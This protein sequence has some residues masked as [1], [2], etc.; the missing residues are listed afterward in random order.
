MAAGTRNPGA[1]PL[2]LDKP[3]IFPDYRADPISETVVNPLIQSNRYFSA[4]FEDSEVSV[5]FGTDRT[6][7]HFL[8][9]EI[10]LTEGLAAS[11]AVDPGMAKAAIEAMRGFSPDLA[12]IEARS[13]VDGLA[14]P[15]FVRQLKAHV[16]ADL[17]PAIHVGGTS[18]DLIDTATVLML[19]EANAILAA[20]LES[21]IDGIEQLIAEHGDNSMMGR[22]RMQ[23]ALPITVRHRLETWAAPLR[24]HRTRLAEMRDELEV[25]QFGG[26]TGDR[27][28]NGDKAAEIAAVMAA[29]LGLSYP[30]RA[31][32][33]DR[34]R[35]VEYA[36]WLSM[37]SGSLGKIGQDICLMAQQGV[38]EIAQT[39]G[40]SS[41]AMAH[42]QNP[43]LAELLVTLARYSAGQISLMHNALLHEQE[44]S[45]TAWTLEWMVLPAMVLVAS[46]GLLV[47][48]QQLAAIA[49][50]GS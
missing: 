2:W 48:K 39:G 27:S 41:S 24:R 47:A 10:A 6:F 4:L 40:G 50:I 22:T 31:W 21:V 9:Y 5:A 33:N 43:V 11:G 20:R 25:L 37:V 42:K 32:H 1:S 19:K 15:E 3:L 30:C 12:A 18:Q 46:K 44:R 16:G 49:R 14:V 36:G 8:A 45:G 7:R 38:D 35:L 17:T 23:A 29:K 26:A 13:P 34:S 28:A